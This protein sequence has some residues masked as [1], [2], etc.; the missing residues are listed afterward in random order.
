MPAKKKKLPVKLSPLL[1]KRKSKV[2]HLKESSSVK[3]SK[4]FPVVGIGASAGGLEAF[5]VL[6]KHLP[7]DLD[8]AYVFVQHLSPNHSSFLSQIISR[9]TSM[10]VHQVRNNLE[11]KKNNIYIIPPGHSLA[12]TD[13]VLQLISE[14]GRH[15]FYPIDLF[16]SSLGRT[17][18]NNAIGIILSGTG[19]DG[20]LGLKDIKAEGGITFAQDEDAHYQ[21]MPRN[22]VELGY[23]DFV[24]SPEEIA[25]E[26][27]SLSK[28]PLTGLMN[29]QE[30]LYNNSQEIEKIHAI[31]FAKKNIDF[32]QYKQT[33]IRRRIMRRMLLNKFHSLAGYVKLLTENSKE[34]AAL[35][36]D[37]LIN[38][39]DFFRDKGMNMALTNTVFPGLIKEKDPNNPIRIWVP[40]CSTG[41][42][43]FT[44]AML[45]IE[46]LG[47]KALTH[48]IQIFGTDL[49]EKSIERARTGLYPQSAVQNISK[50]RLQRFFIKLDGHYQVLKNVRDLCIM[51]PHNLLKD[52]PFSNMDL[53][54]CQNLLIYL[55][56]APQLRIMKT[57][58]YALKNKGFLVLGK[59]ETVGIATDLFEPLG[60]AHKVY[61]RKQGHKVFDLNFAAS[62]YATVYAGSSEEKTIVRKTTDIDK[63][64]EKILLSQYISPGLLV[65][66]DMEIIRFL[67]AVAPYLEPTYGKASFQLMKMVKEEIAYELRSTIIKAKKNNNTEKK[68][69]LQI[70]I[71][72]KNVLVSFDVVPVKGQEREIYFLVI[73][74]KTEIPSARDPRSKQGK[75]SHGESKIKF[76]ES[77]L[78]EARHNVKTISEEYETMREELQSSNEEALSSNEE[79]QS[80]N[81]ELETSKEELQSM[82]EELMTINE[83]LHTRNH[84]LKELTDYADA[85]FESKLETLVILNE[86]LRVKI[87]NKGF[88]NLF[89]TTARETEGKLFY[90]LGRHQWKITDLQ[91][92]LKTVLNNGEPIVNYEVYDEFPGIGSRTMLLNAQVLPQKEE[93]G[94]LILVAIQDITD[95]ELALQ[96]IKTGEDRFRLLVQNAFDII[97]LFTRDGTIEYVSP[98]VENVLG[99]I[100]AEQTGKNILSHTATHPDNNIARENMFRDCLTNPGK[101]I[102]AEFQ[103][104]HKDGSYRFIEAIAKNMLYESS[105]QGIVANYRDI[106]ERKVLEQQKDDFIGIASHELKTP[107]TSIKAY[108]QILEENFIE[109]GNKSA[110]GMAEKMNAQ[111]DRLTHLISD[112]LDFTHIEVNK[113]TFRAETYDINKL[114]REIGDETQR[115]TEKQ[116]IFKLGKTIKIKGDRLRTAE[117]LSNLLSNAIKYSPGANQIII[118]SAAQK[119]E[120]IISVQDFGIGIDAAKADKIFDRFYRVSD[121]SVNT[122]PGLG[123][124]LYLAAEIVRKQGGRIWA[125]SKL[126]KGSTFFFTLPLHAPFAITEV[127]E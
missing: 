56:P 86:D 82:N 110:A 98:S 37:L 52:P 53:I 66:N 126:G 105:I 39:T 77:H 21:G 29:S 7:S 67:G 111:I 115:T 26:L 11:I 65:N 76:L 44:I 95:R 6:L 64:L 79:L 69:G 93:K 31:L 35:H 117:V 97:I 18:K 59:S 90:E 124:G 85:I 94:S 32:T 38:V 3:P 118:G 121:A 78:K 50:E 107:V 88:Y 19:T 101:N 112:L 109:S 92:H 116:L 34:V 16:L 125:E 71:D 45:L 46:F 25:V 20:T 28:N 63:E 30:Y 12:V 83:E 81:E 55:E 47:A 23:V 102:K 14:K 41:E 113:M 49:S 27:I 5:S 120:I 57:F 58:H 119:T 91:F 127:K 13:G 1:K 62:N 80:I 73:F 106:T 54:S 24:L 22:A 74:G 9:R 99:F 60:R 89:Q 70:A 15:N 33:T 84:E 122:F 48:S 43:V 68:E 72:K 2:A 100:P 36:Q 10:P 75:I 17:Y 108:A 123:L 87:A 104:R 96:K 103:L 40:G 51:A 61:Q 42:E 4:Q 114:I 8:M